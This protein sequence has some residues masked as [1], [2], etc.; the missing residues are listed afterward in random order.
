MTL[1]YH[2]I[3][4]HAITGEARHVVYDADNVKWEKLKNPYNY[5][6][7]EHIWRCF[8]IVQNSNLIKYYVSQLGRCKSVQTM[9][10]GSTKTLMMSMKGVG[11]HGYRQIN[12]VERHV[13]PR[14]GSVS[15]STTYPVH[16]LVA[17]FFCVK[18]SPEN[19]EVD[20]INHKRLDNRAV[21]LKWKTRKENLRNRL[22]PGSQ[23]ECYHC[24]RIVVLD[25]LE[26]QPRMNYIPDEEMSDS[27]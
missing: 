11:S 7:T 12:T 23:I 25:N 27:D 8:A 5:S 20:H 17:D 2:D 10:D 24:N 15:N 4:Y 21:N 3:E 18:G 26:I 22:T 9:K 6:Q 16:R 1:P 19:V 14:N 13:R